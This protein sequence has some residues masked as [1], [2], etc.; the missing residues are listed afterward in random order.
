MKRIIFLLTL[1]FSI[2]GCFSEDILQ[3]ETFEEKEVSAISSDFT[4]LRIG[5]NPGGTYTKPVQAYLTCKSSKGWLAKWTVDGSEPTWTNG[6]WSYNPIIIKKTC[7]FKWRVFDLKDKTNYSYV[8]SSEYIINDNSYTPTPYMYNGITFK[9]RTTKGSGDCINMPFDSLT[10]TEPTVRS[11]ECEG[12]FSLKGSYTGINDSKYMMV[13]VKN[14]ATYKSQKFLIEGLNFDKKIWLPFGKGNYEIR[15][16]PATYETVEE[17][18]LDDEYSYLT[19]HSAYCTH[20][21]YVTNTLDYDGTFIFPSQYIQSDNDEIRSKAL[22]V[23][24]QYNALYEQD[25]WKA[26]Y[27]MCYVIDTCSFDHQAY[28][29]RKPQNAL[30][31]LHNG[32]DAVCEGYTSLYVA[33]LR[34]I[35]IKSKA[36]RTD[37]HA[38]AKV[39]DKETSTYKMVD[40][41]WN[42]VDISY[43]HS[44]SYFWK[45]DG[46][47]NH[48]LETDDRPNR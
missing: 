14:T 46:I 6:G 13:S 16:Y 45:E 20:L 34:S 12:F 18:K 40:C 5:I 9:G 29:Y 48:P 21:F 41:L 7:T 4:N 2:V 25:K 42:D 24:T 31:I 32:N 47:Y 26:F 28:F 11:F 3:K 17:S 36:V 30:Y 27:L 23:L 15:I 38:W 19:S 10:I 1:C 22:E 33:L 39:W 44:T 35:G 37:T 43:I 8:A